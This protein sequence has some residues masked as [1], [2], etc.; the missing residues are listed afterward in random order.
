MADHAKDKSRASTVDEFCARWRISRTT[1]YEEVRDRKLVLRKIRGRSVVTS[2][3]EAA[4]VRA[5]PVVEP[6]AA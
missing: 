4:W 6:T 5:L 2:D 1:F 3:D